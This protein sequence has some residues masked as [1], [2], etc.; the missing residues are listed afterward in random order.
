MT[1][2]AVIVD[3]QRVLVE[4]F[5]EILD[6]FGMEVRATNKPLEALAIVQEF[7][8]DLIVADYMMPGIDGLELCRRIRAADLTPIPKIIIASAFMSTFNAEIEAKRAGADAL[9]HKPISIDALRKIFLELFPGNMAIRK[10][11]LQ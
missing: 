10:A 2:R 8:P 7:K 4:M 1:M 6:L 3:D 9:L 11:L 5:T